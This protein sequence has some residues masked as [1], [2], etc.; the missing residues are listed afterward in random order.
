MSMR[1]LSSF[2]HSEMFLSVVDI[3]IRVWALLFSFDV[4]LLIEMQRK[5]NNSY[6]SIQTA[7]YPSNAKK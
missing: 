3:S 1:P 5:F 7:F 2:E 4:M 6:Q